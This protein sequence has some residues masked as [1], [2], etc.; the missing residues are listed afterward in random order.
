MLTKLY[1]MKKNK[2]EKLDRT[3]K[4]NV[5]VICIM[6]ILISRHES[7]GGILSM[8]RAEYSFPSIMQS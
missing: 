1:L 7:R 4:D 3:L 6:Q 2:S 8:A 5:K